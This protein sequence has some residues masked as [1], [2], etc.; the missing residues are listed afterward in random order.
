ML[1]CM[2]CCMLCGGGNPP[3]PLLMLSLCV[4]CV[5]VCYLFLSFVCMCCCVYGVI[6]MCVRVVFVCGVPGLRCYDAD[7]VLIGDRLHLTH[8]PVGPPALKAIPT[9]YIGCE[10]L[11]ASELACGV[12][13]SA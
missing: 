12:L 6:F 11:A 8:L 4:C 2:L 13:R 5:Y 10:G 3:R 9:Q 7:N 1:C